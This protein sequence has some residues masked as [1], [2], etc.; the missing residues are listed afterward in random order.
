[1]LTKKPLMPTR[2]KRT[3]VNSDRIADRRVR[4]IW[5]KAQVG[6]C[7]GLSQSGGF[8]KALGRQGRFFLFL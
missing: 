1:M 8:D 5:N 4:G 3:V 7:A 6:G 2:R